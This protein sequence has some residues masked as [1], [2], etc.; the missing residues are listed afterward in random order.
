MG[1][2][3][4]PGLSFK[5]LQ[6]SAQRE[7]IIIHAKPKEGKT[8]VALTA[9]A[10]FD[11]GGKPG[12]I[13]DVGVITFDATGLAY[14]KA[15]G[16]EFSYWIDMSDHMDKGLAHLDKALEASIKMMK[17]LA[18]AKKIHTLIIDPITTLDVFWLA[19][20]AKSYEKWQ[21]VEQ[22]NLKHKRFLLDMLMPVPCN[23]VITAH[24]KKLGAMEDAAKKDSLGLDAEDTVVLD[25]G[26]YNGPK[27]Y[28][29]Q[30]SVMLPL[31]CTRGKTVKEDNYSLYPRGYKGMEAGSRYPELN[32]IDKMPANLKEV[33]KIIKSAR[34]A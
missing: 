29:T 23:L 31:S 32:A 25:I 26:G 8:T 34:V 6:Q 1:E 17:E 5:S 3:T 28:R 2:V 16:Y 33:F 11:L 4:I 9:S 7:C 30:A 27:L 21:L 14:T 22:G 12:L 24:N 15:L 19:E 13:D 18:I 20:L 10:K